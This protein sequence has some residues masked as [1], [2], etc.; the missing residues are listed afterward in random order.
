MESGLQESQK[1]RFGIKG[2]PTNCTGSNKLP[3]QSRPDDRFHAAILHSQKREWLFTFPPKRSQ[4]KV[5]PMLNEKLSIKT[6]DPRWSTVPCRIACKCD[7]LTAKKNVCSTF[8]V[9]HFWQKALLNWLANRY[10]PPY[11]S[12]NSV[13]WYSWLVGC[14]N[15]GNRKEKYISPAVHCYH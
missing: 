3:A 5:A 2:N 14:S 4:R 15:F 13:S 10:P 6:L 9:V 8:W 11:Q 1:M 7:S 12:S